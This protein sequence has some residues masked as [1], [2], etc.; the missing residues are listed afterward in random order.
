MD[1]SVSDRISTKDEFLDPFSK[2]NKMI[3]IKINKM[4]FN[5]FQGHFAL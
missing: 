4:M 5:F 1:I 3:I 2:Q